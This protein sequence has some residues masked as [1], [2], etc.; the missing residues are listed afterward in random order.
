MATDIASA[1]ARDPGAPDL[2]ELYRWS[3]QD[4]E[5]HAT[6]LRLMYERL[7]P[8]H[9]PT[10]LRED[11]A[12]TSAEA[13]AWLALGSGRRAVAVDFDGPTVAWARARAHRILGSRAEALQ[14][15]E[16]DVM[17][18]APPAVAAADILS[19]LN[20][21]ILYLRDEAALQAY[22]RHARQCVASPGVLVLNLFGGAGALK[23]RTDRHAVTPRPRLPGEAAIPPF[24]YLWEQRSFDP[25]T[26]RL[27]CRI[28]FRI[29]DPTGHGAPRELRDA[30]R[31]DWRLWTPAE[32]TAHLREAGFDDVQV[33]RHTHDPARGA[34]GI[35]LGAVPPTALDALDLWTAY[36]VASRSAGPG[37]VSPD[38]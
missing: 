36:I 29:P 8:G 4:P 6:V 22:L 24:E 7:H 26:R 17:A 30:F 18:A 14:F 37:P 31:Y 15:I 11:F 12:G 25:H 13:V 34:A 32:L 10:L 33:W 21:S 9:R 35:F 1:T 20:F 19:V 23:P 3:V 28:H 16:A 5:T 38:P 2:L 27:D